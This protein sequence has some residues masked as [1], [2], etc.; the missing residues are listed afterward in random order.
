MYWM[1]NGV[2]HNVRNLP[3]QYEGDYNDGGTHTSHTIT[4]RSVELQWNGTT[5][6]CNVDGCLSMVGTLYICKC[7]EYLGSKHQLLTSFFYFSNNYRTYQV[8]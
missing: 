8:L 7:K 3:K 1:I 4:I 2:A 6:Q 5:H